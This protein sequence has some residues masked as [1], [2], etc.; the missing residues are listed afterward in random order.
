MDS[1]DLA[2]KMI[3]LAKNKELINKYSKLSLERAEYF[4]QENIL[5]DWINL[6]EYLI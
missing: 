3:S 5:S 4:N 6:I 1:E 2:K